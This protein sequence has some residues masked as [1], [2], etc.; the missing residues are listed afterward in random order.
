LFK[1]LEIQMTQKG[2]KVFYDKLQFIKMNKE[3]Y[4]VNSIEKIT[5]N[6]DNI[7]KWKKIDNMN[8]VINF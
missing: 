6:K 3:K 2:I 7:I 1:H 8:I 4:N 5:L